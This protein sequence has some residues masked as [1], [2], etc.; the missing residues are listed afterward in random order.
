M[1]QYVLINKDLKCAHSCMTASFKD[2][3]M[4]STSC[5]KIVPHEK[6]NAI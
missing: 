2:A 5:G 3:V 1:Y 4:P 6:P